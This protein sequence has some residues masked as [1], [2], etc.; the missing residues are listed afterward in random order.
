MIRQSDRIQ[1]RNRM[2]RLRSEVNVNATNV[3][4]THCVQTFVCLLS[5]RFQSED[6]DDLVTCRSFYVC[7]VHVYLA[8]KREYHVTVVMVVTVVVAMM[9]VS[10]VVE[11]MVAENI[12]WTS[13]I[14]SINARNGRVLA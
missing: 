13:L 14:Q 3:D 10:V 11:R 9:V 4:G 2:W 8:S 5:N 1:K 6:W 12:H 7:N